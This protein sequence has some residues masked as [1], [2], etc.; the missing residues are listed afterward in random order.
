SD[1][2]GR[3][4]LHGEIFT[5]DGTHYHYKKFTYGKDATHTGVLIAEVSQLLAVTNQ[6]LVFALFFVVFLL[7]VALAVFLAIRF[8]QKIVQPV[9][10]L[11]EA[12]KRN[13]NPLPT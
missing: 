5:P 7:A 9:L 11:T 8:S 4:Q 2:I 1:R 13:E 10:N 12:V 3:A 6:P